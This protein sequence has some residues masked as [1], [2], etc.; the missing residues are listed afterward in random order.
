MPNSVK[1]H[2]FLNYKPYLK[3]AI[4]VDVAIEQG[5]EILTQHPIVTM[6]NYEEIFCGHP[7]TDECRTQPTLTQVELMR[8]VAERRD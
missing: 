4:A 7:I 2:S 5:W 8:L 6:E 3:S 1:P